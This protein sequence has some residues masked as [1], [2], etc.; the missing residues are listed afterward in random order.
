MING[1]RVPVIRSCHNYVT[2]Y[3]MKILEETDGRI[4]V[5]KFHRVAR[6]SRHLV[7]P[8][9]TPWRGEGLETWLHP[10]KGVAVSNGNNVYYSRT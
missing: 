3:C 9:R 4:Y 5:T 1:R 6:F 7:G 2:C 8:H 10:S